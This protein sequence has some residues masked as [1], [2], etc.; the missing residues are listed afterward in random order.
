LNHDFQN[1]TN[2]PGI[3]AERAGSGERLVVVAQIFKAVPAMLDQFALAAEASMQEQSAQH[4]AAVGV[5]SLDGARARG[6]AIVRMPRAGR[7]ASETVVISDG[8]AARGRP[9]PGRAR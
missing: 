9:V 6:A 8:R 2:M 3:L 7:S 1:E 4:S 5:F